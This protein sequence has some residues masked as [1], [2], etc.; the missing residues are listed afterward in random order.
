MTSPF[1]GAGQPFAMPTV[2][3]VV[4]T[5][6]EA[7]NLPYFFERLPRNVFEV[8]LV[9][10]GSTDG[11]VQVARELYPSVVVV[12]QTRTGKGNALACGF[13][14][15]KGDIL[16]MVDADGSTDPAE[17]TRFIDALLAGADYAKGS[18]FIDG[19]DSHDITHFRRFGNHGLNGIVNTLF[20]TRFTDLCYGY[21]AFWRSALDAFD[22]LDTSLPRPA[23]GRKLWG[24]GFEIETLINIRAA[25]HG[26]N[27]TEVPS[28]EA[29]RIHGVS[30]LNAFG[31]GTRVLRTI[32]REFRRL[33]AERRRG[34][35]NSD[36]PSTAQAVLDSSMDADDRYALADT[37]EILRR[38]P[39]PA[40]RTQPAAL[41]EDA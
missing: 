9:D 36:A 31:D 40:T 29:R 27:I 28:I 32:F 39:M 15:S 30:N 19:G 25:A 33:R 34:A 12:S 6:N 8:I 18:R 3:V 11:T 10:G 4:P 41:G 5:L 7:R 35:H 37:Q 20:R 23:D 2:S 21:N 38:Q 22:M 26:L 14:A 16:V 17:M 13:D 24:D 1:R